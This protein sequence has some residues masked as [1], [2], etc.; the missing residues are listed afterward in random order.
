[1]ESL[2]I[3]CRTGRK[4]R[5]KLTPEEIAACELAVESATA[6][7]YSQQ[8]KRDEAIAQLRGTAIGNAV[9]TLLGVGE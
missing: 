6:Q 9:L 8:Q 1:M 5:H 4:T 3:D 7:E 2:T